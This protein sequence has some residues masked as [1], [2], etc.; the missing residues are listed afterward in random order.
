MVDEFEWPSGEARDYWMPGINK[1]HVIEGNP[2]FHSRRMQTNGKHCPG[3]DAVEFAASRENR[4]GVSR[5]S[6][7]GR[8]AWTAIRCKRLSWEKGAKEVTWDVPEGEWLITVYDLVPAG[9][10]W[11]GWT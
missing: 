3:A 4:R 11:A 7:W 1:S 9:P 6:A 2:E 8:A 5:Q 10:N